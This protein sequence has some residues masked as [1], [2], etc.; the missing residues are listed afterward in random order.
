MKRTEEKNEKKR[1]QS[2]R[3]CLQE[4]EEEAGQNYQKED[5]VEENEDQNRGRREAKGKK[6]KNEVTFIHPPLP[7]PNLINH[8]P[9]KTS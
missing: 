4:Q 6:K 5:K 3:Y 8:A 9:P 2:D 1:P 7:I